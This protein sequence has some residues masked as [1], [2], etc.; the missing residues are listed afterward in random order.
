MM[1]THI[2]TTF[3]FPFNVDIYDMGF[4]KVLNGIHKH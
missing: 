3:K 1:D 4:N 2:F